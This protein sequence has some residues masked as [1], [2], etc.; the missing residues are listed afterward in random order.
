MLIGAACA[1]AA[2]A[3]VVAEACGTDDKGV[4]PGAPAGTAA[5]WQPNE[6]D[7]AGGSVEA[8][9]RLF[10][11]AFAASPY[12]AA[13]T[14]SSAAKPFPQGEKLKVG[15]IFVGSTKDLGYNQ[16]A[17]DG[18]QWLQRALPDI[19]ILY[20]ENVPE[21]AQVQAVEEQMIQQGAT[22]IFATSF[23]YADPTLELARKY[24]EVVFLH[25]GALTSAQNFTAYLGEMWQLEYAAGVVA[26]KMTRTGKLGYIGAF[27]I[28]P[29]LLNV[30]AFQLGARSANPDVTT[31]F[32][33]TGSWCDPA[34][35][36]AAVQALAAS[37]VDVVNQ[38]QD[39]TGTIAEAAERA[40]LYTVG[41]HLDAGSVAPRAW[42]TGAVWNWGPVYAKLVS[43]ARRGYLR[44]AVIF[45][46]LE[47]GFV[48]MA[49]FGASVPDDVRQLALRAVEAQRAGDLVPF[50]GPIRDRDGNLKVGPGIRLSKNEL[51]S[52]DW[53]VEGVV[54]AR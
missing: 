51:Q 52:T 27:P 25:Q 36:A 12:P 24:P 20:A 30:N 13:S 6:A 48:K 22:V 50:T 21:T 28:P 2:L 1:L 3:T 32:V 14:F 44:G 23:G 34:K 19:E 15:F 37:G 43:E 18:S 5:A 39:C 11:E 4:T 17:H 53:L 49:P 10:E 54:G 33:V 38:H 45:G 8:F 29:T 31:T 41:F 35:Q 26:G 9:D 40:G 16:A 42:L 46:G 47:A 7:L